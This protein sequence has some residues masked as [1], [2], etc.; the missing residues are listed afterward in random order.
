MYVFK[1][2]TYLWKKTRKIAKGREITESTILGVHDFP[3][4]L[5]DNLEITKPVSVIFFLIGHFDS[6]FI[7]AIDPNH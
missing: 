2:K 3:L 4:S 6:L 5:V 7:K 1:M